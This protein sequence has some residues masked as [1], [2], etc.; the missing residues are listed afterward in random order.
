MSTR[1]HVSA[2]ILPAFVRSRSFIM[3]AAE[4]RD[5]A[6]AADNVRLRRGLRRARA[7]LQQ[8]DVAL[9]LRHISEALTAPPRAARGHLCAV[10]GKKSRTVYQMEQTGRWQNEPPERRRLCC[11][12][13]RAPP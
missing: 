2:A 4:V 12:C 13:D 3:D 10:C 11:T 1:F 5:A 9:A 6:A 8:N 7:A